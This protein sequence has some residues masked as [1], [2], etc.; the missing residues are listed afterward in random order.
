DGYEYTAEYK[1]QCRWTGCYENCPAGWIR[2]LRKDSGA[3]GE[4]YMVDEAGCGGY[5]QHQLCC[6]P[7]Q[8]PPTCGWYTH[9]NGRCAN[10][11]PAGTKEIGSNAKY[12]QMA[13]AGTSAY[14][15]YQAAC[16]TT[17]TENMKLYGQCD[18]TTWPFCNSASGGSCPASQTTVASSGTGSGDAMCYAFPNPNSKRK[19]CCD[20]DDENSQ[21]T[22]CAW[23]GDLSQ[24]STPHPAD[25][26]HANCPQDTVRVA[27]DQTGCSGGSARAECCTP[28]IKAISKRQSSQDAEYE[29][30]LEIFLMSPVCVMSGIYE[31]WDVDTIEARDLMTFNVESYTVALVTALFWGKPTVSQ[32]DLWNRQIAAVT[33]FASLS[34][35]NLHDYLTSSDA[36]FIYVSLGSTQGAEYIVCNLNLVASSVANWL[37]GKGGGGGGGGSSTITCACVRSDCCAE[38]DAECIGF[39]TDS[40]FA[41]RGLPMSPAEDHASHALDK[42]GKSKEYTVD[43][44][45]HSTTPIT[46]IR[47]S[48]VAPAYPSTAQFTS[49]RDD[50][51]LLEAWD[52]DPNCPQF[53]PVSTTVTPVGNTPRTGF[54]SEH[55]FERHAVAQWSQDAIDGVLADHATPFTQNGV[56]YRLPLSFFTSTLTLNLQNMAGPA[57]GGAAYTDFRSRIMNAL[58]STPNRGVMALVRGK[59]NTIKEQIWLLEK[60]P[61]LNTKMENWLYGSPSGTPPNVPEALRQIRNVLATYQFH[62]EATINNNLKTVILAIRLEIRAA[63][64]LHSANFGV[65]VHARDHFDAWVKSFFAEMTA[66]TQTWLNRHINSLELVSP[67]AQITALIP[68][69][70]A[71]T[72]SLAITQTGFYI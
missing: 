68:Q 11:C 55:V 13:S 72:N 65:T 10:Q 51:I 47:Y 69:L 15:S 12:C 19:Y 53:R 63:E 27:M 8:T 48:W 36:S 37:A 43:V 60:E 9:N 34:Y 4:E 30:Y 32:K 24:G 6:P 39:D 71:A 67:N 56:H 2:M 44:N 52:F 64:N 50:A 41:A 62:N 5:G 25:F 59:M 23:H 29:A 21:W 14:H 7:S 49:P 57:A 1:Q 54:H 42:R 26:C 38:G 66:L 20:N 46:V 31:H 16:C 17:G 33:Q 45:D 35:A 70:R 3:S 18:W 40:E 28:N 58:G 61:V 22:E